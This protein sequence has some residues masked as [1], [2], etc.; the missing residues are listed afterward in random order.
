MGTYAAPQDHSLPCPGVR[1]GDSS[2]LDPINVNDA[3]HLHEGEDDQIQRSCKTVKDLQ[4][5][6]SRLQCEANG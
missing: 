3:H 5:V 1:H 4:P 2:P 6:A